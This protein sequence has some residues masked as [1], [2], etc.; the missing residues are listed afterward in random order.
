MHHPPWKKSSKYE[1][2]DASKHPYSNDFMKNIF[3]S[4]RYGF[5]FNILFLIRKYSARSQGR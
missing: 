2:L 1:E 5:G 4:T 3:A